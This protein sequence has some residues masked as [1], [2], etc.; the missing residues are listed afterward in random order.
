MSAMA[1]QRSLRVAAIALAALLGGC[2]TTGSKVDPLEPMNRAMFEVHDVV[3]G[4]VIKPLAEAYVAV[5]PGLVRT[6]LSNFYNNIDDLFS[7][8]NGL[9]QGKTEKAGHDFGR[10]MVNTLFGVLGIFDPASDAGIERGNEDF[11]QTFAYWG[12]P[13]GPYLF[14]PLFGPTTVVDGAGFVVRV[15]WGPVGEIPDVA[16]RNSLYGLGYMNTRAGLLEAGQIVDAAALDRYRFI[17]NAYLQKRRYEVYDGKPPP[18][19]E[20]E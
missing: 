1:L 8:I 9:L 19:P 12:L 2:A 14:V 20:D 7:G 16:V 18:E 5:M 15:L 4:N 10:V 6:G 17:R 11:G 3:D 13:S